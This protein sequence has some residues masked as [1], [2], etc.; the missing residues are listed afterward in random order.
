MKLKQINPID[1]S[2]Q[3]EEESTQIL[4]KIGAGEPIKHDQT[5]RVKKDGVIINVSLSISPTKNKL[6]RL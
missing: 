5:K 4:K 2:A 3:R 1:Y 6:V